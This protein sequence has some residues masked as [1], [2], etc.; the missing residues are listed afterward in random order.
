MNTLAGK[1][2]IGYGLFLAAMG[3][4]GYLSNP[5]K[6][7]TALLSGGLF[8]AL[9]VTWGVL[10]LRQVGWSRKAAVV[11]T[12]LLT[13]VFLWRAAAGWVAVAQGRADKQTAA[14]LVSLMLV[15]SVPMLVL[16]LRPQRPEAARR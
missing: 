3:V 9:S 6:A 16:L 2:L 4:A 5:E 8:G 11:T 12:L 10:L 14:I 7:Q 15:A 13:V 1:F